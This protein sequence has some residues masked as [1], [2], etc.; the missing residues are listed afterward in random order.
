MERVSGLYWRN[1]SLLSLKGRVHYVASTSAVV[2]AA[3]LPSNNRGSW[4]SPSGPG[5]RLGAGQKAAS[6]GPPSL[7]GRRVRRRPGEAPCCDAQFRP[8]V[9]KEQG[10]GRG[11]K[12][13]PQNPAR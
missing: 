1:N 8:G 2:L 6:G 12:P 7:Q 11:S 9:S 13:D 10:G 5:E 4:Q 3:A